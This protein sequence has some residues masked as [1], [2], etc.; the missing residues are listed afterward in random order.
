MLAASHKS[1]PVFARRTTLVTLRKTTASAA[2]TARLRNIC[3]CVPEAGRK[4]P[5]A[6]SGAERDGAG[7][8]VVLAANWERPTN[9]GGSATAL[10]LLVENACPQSTFINRSNPAFISFIWQEQGPVS[11]RAIVSMTSGLMPS[12]TAGGKTRPR[13]NTGYN[14]GRLSLARAGCQLRS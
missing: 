6:K 12:P 4:P 7:P 13:P 9:M 8:L 3:S 10:A 11:R 1:R 5:E 14:I 2:S